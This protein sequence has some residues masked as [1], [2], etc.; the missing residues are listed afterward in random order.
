MAKTI[1]QIQQELCAPLRG[2]DITLRIGRKASGG[3]FLLAYKD[4]RVDARRLNDVV[5]IFGWKREHTFLEGKNYCTVSIRNP[6]TGEWISKQDCGTESNTEKEKGESSDAFKR[7]CFAWGIGTELYDMPKI[8][9][10][11][12][13][14]YPDLSSYTINMAYDKTTRKLV[15]L[16]VRDEHGN[17]AYQFKSPEYNKEN[18]F[19][20]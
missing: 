17:V 13:T 19:V 4:A 10:K 1:E 9:V 2:S 14:Q 15:L 7:A 6:E 3:A 11:L 5:G 12:N 20:P 8:F 18:I 16:V